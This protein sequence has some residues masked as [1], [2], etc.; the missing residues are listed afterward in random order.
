MERL[1]A[2]GHK[3]AAFFYWL[4]HGRDGRTPWLR[5]ISA[6]A[7]FFA[8]PAPVLLLLVFRFV[9][10][11]GTPEMLFKLLTLNSVHYSW[12][13]FGAISPNLA[14]AVIGGLLFATPTT[15][16]FVPYLFAVLRKGNDGK[17]AHGVFVEEV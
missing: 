8:L 10:I 13:D 16:L 12:R 3:I 2:L 15:L 11:P 1:G 7:F 5:R 4:W 6:M 9:P 14:R 17:K